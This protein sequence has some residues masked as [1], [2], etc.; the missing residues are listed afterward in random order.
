MRVGDYR[1]EKIFAIRNVGSLPVCSHNGSRSSLLAS[2]GAKVFEWNTNT[3]AVESR[4]T[5][6]YNAQYFEACHL[7]L[8]FCVIN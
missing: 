6:K 7:L 2:V 8:M 3:A 1:Q 5:L 4:W